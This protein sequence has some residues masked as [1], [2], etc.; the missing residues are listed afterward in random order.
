[1][2]LRKIANLLDAEGRAVIYK[3]QVRS[4]MEYDSLCWINASPTNLR[5]LDNIQKKALKV[6]GVDEATALMQLNITSLLHRRQVAAATVLYKMQ[7][8]HCPAELTILKTSCNPLQ[9][10]IA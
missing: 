4:I 10:F 7:T 8:R 3:S 1:M 2:A 5:Q 6:I 9:C